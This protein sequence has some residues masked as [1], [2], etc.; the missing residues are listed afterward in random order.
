MDNSTHQI[1][2]ARINAWQAI[3]VAVIASL[4]GITGTIGVNYFNRTSTISEKDEVIK[5][6][7]ESSDKEVKQLKEKIAHYEQDLA[8]TP[9][10]VL[11]VVNL[12]IN[13]RECLERLTQWHRTQT[14]KV[15][16]PK[17]SM[18]ETS[19]DGNFISNFGRFTVRVACSETHNTAAVSVSLPYRRDENIGIDQVVEMTNSVI[20]ILQ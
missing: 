8:S 6:L 7:Q 17:F 19:Y 15:K 10:V 4:T 13:S 2:I 11:R 18:Q 5:Q 14:P 1:K 20:A 12:K 9:L 3:I 16:G